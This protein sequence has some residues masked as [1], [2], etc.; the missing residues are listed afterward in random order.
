MKS[1]AISSHSQGGKVYQPSAVEEMQ[2]LI[3]S[4]QTK[5]LLKLIV[6]SQII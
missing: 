3:G 1:N 5:A 6:L 2:D 4:V